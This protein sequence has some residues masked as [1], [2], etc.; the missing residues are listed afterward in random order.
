MQ[1]IIYQL[2]TQ[3]IQRAAKQNPAI[4]GSFKIEYLCASPNTTYMK[5]FHSFR[6]AG[7]IACATLIGC[8]TSNEYWSQQEQDIINDPTDIL[9]VLTVSQASDSLVL[10]TRC[11]NLSIEEIQ[12]DLYKTLCKKMIATVTS[13]EQ[14]GVGIAG[15]QVGLSRR[16]VA[17]QRFDKA[18]Y[19]FEVYPNIRITERR[20]EQAIGPEGCLSVPN[21][22]G[23][24]LR[25]QDIDI[26]YTSTHSLKDT[27]EHI[28]GYTA[29]IFQHETDHLDGILY[30]D[31]L[32]KEE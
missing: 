27:T 28:Q 11:R 8:S 19:P 25:W 12:D 7:L 10:R 16:I 24:V 26:C 6:I 18:G 22:S 5:V 4:A 1:T 2:F 20:G 23:N 17:V 13:P 3:N 21:R 31:K 14:D 32:V 30:T 29:V 9:R 15:P